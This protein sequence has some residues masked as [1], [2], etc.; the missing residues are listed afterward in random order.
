M[1]ECL[2]KRKDLCIQ[3]CALLRPQPS[4]RDSFSTPIPTVLAFSFLPRWAWADFASR[5]TKKPVS[6]ES[7]SDRD[8]YDN[9]TER[10]QRSRIMWNYHCFQLTSSLCVRYHIHIRFCAILYNNVGKSSSPKHTVHKNQH[11]NRY[12]KPQILMLQQQTECISWCMERSLIWMPHSANRRKIST[13][14]FEVNMFDIVLGCIYYLTKENSHLTIVCWWC[15]SDQTHWLGTR[16]RDPQ[17][18]MSRN[19]LQIL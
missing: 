6:S 17:R 16:R 8:V 19:M 18:F 11:K 12:G 2:L 3:S 1:C 10:G 5:G 7:P 9:G 13:N 4:L 14:R 15:Y